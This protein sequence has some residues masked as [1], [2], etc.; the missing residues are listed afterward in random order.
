MVRA[1]LN[2]RKKLYM[3]N[4]LIG[5][6]LILLGTAGFTF[7][8]AS[9]HKKICRVLKCKQGQVKSRIAKKIFA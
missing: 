7:L 8:L 1:I 6:C 3:G 4:I 2:E 9:Q 5:L